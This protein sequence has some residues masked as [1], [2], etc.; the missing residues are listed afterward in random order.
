MTVYVETDFLL[1]LA[2][3]DDWLKEPAREAVNS[4]E[5]ETSLAAFIE[6]LLISER[7]AFDR[8]RACADLLQLVSIVPESDAQIVLKAAKYQ[9]EHAMTAF[10]AVHAATAETRGQPIMSSERDYDVL[11]INRVPLENDTGG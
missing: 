8:V 4:R 1:A 11:D 7:F 9:E 6:L 2:K 5:I 3:P 10:D